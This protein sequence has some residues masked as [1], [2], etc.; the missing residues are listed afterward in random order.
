MDHSTSSIQDAFLIFLTLQHPRISCTCQH[1]FALNQVVQQSNLSEPITICFQ[2]ALDLL[3]SFQLQAKNE[4]LRKV[5][6]A[7]S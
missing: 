6:Y 1:S 7:T 5:S 3:S 4:P 2:L